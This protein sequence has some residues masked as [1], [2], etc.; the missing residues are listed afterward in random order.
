MKCL[1]TFTLILICLASTSATPKQDTL[2]KKIVGA[3]RLVSVQGTD[4]TVH[5]EYD[6]PTGLII[7]DQSGWMGVQIAVKGA[8]KP[9]ANGVSSGTVEEKAAAFDN[10]VAYYG[11]YTLDPRAGTVTHHLESHSYPGVKGVNTVRWFEFQGNDRLVLVP[12]EDGKGGVIV[13]KDAHYKLFWERI[14]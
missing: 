12:V 6:H 5:V 9:F 7:Y 8:R 11:T 2:A 4:P 3:W 1:A 14:K 13:R 10:Y